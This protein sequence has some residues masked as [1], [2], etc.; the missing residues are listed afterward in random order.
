MPDMGDVIGAGVFFFFIGGFFSCVVTDDHANTVCNEQ[1]APYVKQRHDYHDA[2][3]I[4]QSGNVIV[5]AVESPSQEDDRT[6]ET[7]MNGKLVS[8]TRPQNFDEIWDGLRTWKPSDD[9]I[10]RQLEAPTPGRTSSKT[11]E[12]E[13]H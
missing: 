11:G 8:R 6:V 7:I 2:R 12:A 13:K 5:R 10:L 4:S 1:L 9:W 3:I